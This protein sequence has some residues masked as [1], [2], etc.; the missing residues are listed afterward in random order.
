MSIKLSFGVFAIAVISTLI[1]TRIYIQAARNKRVLGRDVNKAGKPLVPEMG[2]FAL[3]G[4]LIFAALAGL[5]YLTFIEPDFHLSTLVLAVICSVT[6]V[7]LIGVFDDLFKLSWKTKS[8]LPLIAAFPLM[9]ITAGNTSISLPFLPPIDLGFYYTF[10]LI[11]L[12]I[13]GA[14]NAVNMSGGYNGLEAGI[15][16][17][18]SF[19]LLAI[20]IHSNEVGA[21]I[22]LAALLGACI[23]FLKF[24]W[25]PSRVFPGDIGT[26]VIGTGIA[27]AVIIGNMERFGVILLIPAFYELAS[28]I[29]YGFKGVKRREA[30]H[31]PLIDAKGKLKPPRGAENY[32]LF[33]YILSKNPM[34][35][36]ELV[37]TVLMLYFFFG[38]IALGIYITQV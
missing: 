20:A 1:F 28:T 9:A 24:N 2:G 33:Y 5:L 37:K 22:I 35:E 25:Y 36:K 16:A 12:G 23:A 32:T 8:L 31:N 3:F 17:I 18:V 13:T 4:G 15:G 29:Y 7:A 34:N 6:I 27:S 38:L 21:Q 26:L 14:A 30:C 11:P 10:L 19:F